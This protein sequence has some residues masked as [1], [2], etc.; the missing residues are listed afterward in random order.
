M[1]KTRKVRVGANHVTREEWAKRHADAFSR[2]V[3]LATT[4]RISQQRRWHDGS[5]MDRKHRIV[6]RADADVRDVSELVL[7]P[8][9]DPRCL[10]IIAGYRTPK[11]S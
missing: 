6:E 11:A 2:R 1:S 3:L 10:P 8:H 4:H 7:I 9:S 5:L